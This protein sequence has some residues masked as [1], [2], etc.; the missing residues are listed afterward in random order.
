MVKTSQVCI[1][2]KIHT[3]IH[4]TPFDVA[5]FHVCVFISIIYFIFHTVG[6]LLPSADLNTRRWYMQCFSSTG[7]KL[8]AFHFFNTKNAIACNKMH[9]PFK[10]LSTP[11][12]MRLDI[13]SDLL[14]FAHSGGFPCMT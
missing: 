8:H 9:Y 3:Q 11:Y 5:D 1:Q 14:V 12:R 2:S 6:L 7:T 4:C 13:P 10:L